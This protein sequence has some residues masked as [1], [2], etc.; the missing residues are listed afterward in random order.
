MVIP[1]TGLSVRDAPRSGTS[2]PT[3]LDACWRYKYAVALCVLAAL[4]NG[5][6]VWQLA[7][8]VYQSSA[9]VLVVKK[10]PD[11]VSGVEPRNSPVEDF[12]ATHQ[13]LIQSPLIVERAVRRSDLGALPSFSGREDVTEAVIK[14]LTVS[15][16]RS[17]SGESNVIRV[18]CRCS[19]PE[20]C[21][22]ALGAVLAS[23]AEFLEE[24]YQ[25]TSNDTLKL[26]V[27]ARDRLQKDLERREAEY[28]EFRKKDPLF[29]KAKEGLDLRLKQLDAVQAKRSGLLLQKAEIEGQLA[30]LAKARQEGQSPETLRTMAAEF[31]P[32]GEREGVGRDKLQSLQDQLV[33]LLLEEQRLLQ[34]YGPNHPEV[35]SVRERIKAAR[36]F[37]T[38]PSPTLDRVTSEGKAATGGDLAELYLRYAR[39]KLMELET[40]EQLLGRLFE[41]EQREATK[42]AVYEAENQ[43][44]RAGL[45]RTQ[46][47]YDEIVKR[48][49]DFG[50]A[51]EVGGYDARTIAPPS[52]ARKVA[53]NPVLVLPV[54]LALGLGLGLAWARFGVWLAGRPAAVRGTPPDEL[55]LAGRRYTFAGDR[56]E[57]PV[58]PGVPRPQDAANGSR[59]SGG[60]DGSP[61]R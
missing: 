15:R 50:L 39:Q 23:Y 25:V 9:Q 51:R 56:A 38:R 35:R 20:D 37:L 49:G 55:V 12:V 32:R 8:S 34:S 58:A 31:S 18:D 13:L 7:P 1:P 54:A 60:G 52:R 10:R 43:N 57:A 5:V 24:T 6:L 27:Q 30:A 61:T 19:R 40:S 11:G 28:V 29:G 16:S 22:T 14:A 44:R 36:E 33:P 48:V 47:R 45:A 26:A 59:L 4:A 3:L 2:A 53:P 42:L 41:Q 17:Q 46:Q 21:R